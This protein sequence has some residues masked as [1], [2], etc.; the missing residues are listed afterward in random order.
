MQTTAKS[1]DILMDIRVVL[2]GLLL[3][4][5]VIRLI[6]ASLYR[7]LIYSHKD[8]SSNK[9]GITLLVYACNDA[10]NIR[11]N[12]KYLLDQDYPDFDVIVVNDGSTDETNIELKRLESSYSNLYHTYLPEE[13]KTLVR[14]KLAITVGLKAVRKEWV[15]LTTANTRPDSNNWLS[16]MAQEMTPKRDIVLGYSGIISKKGG[17][18]WFIQQNLRHQIRYLSYAKSHRA[19]MG[20]GNNLAIRH[21]AFTSNLMSGTLNL[22]AGEDD[23][24][25][26][27][28]ATKANS[29]VATSPEASV[30][31]LFDD[32]SQG[33]YERI[34]KYNITRGYYKHRSYRF[35]WLESAA[36]LSII[37][38]ILLA[39]YMY[40]TTSD[41]IILT[42]TLS[43]SVIGAICSI[44][45]T[46]KTVRQLEPKSTILSQIISEILLSLIDIRNS[47]I[48][49]RG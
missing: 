16:A 9:P 28:L 30:R 10:D 19:Y 22:N 39:I 42:S 14:R 1:L 33:W 2:P 41:W 11:E 35:W 29:A 5:W 8:I 17:A 3:I 32:I 37:V 15:I 18:A 12:L 47:L 48:G 43:I 36:H 21:S 7:K 26:N 38:L 25:V 46:Y 20:V 27:R 40:I 45:L 6:Y 24:T 44:A 31:V 49:R 23:I 13:A 34:F 4:L